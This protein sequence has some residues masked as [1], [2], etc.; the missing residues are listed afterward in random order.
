MIN[1]PF[2]AELESANS[3]D[4]YDNENKL[5]FS[6]INDNEDT[7]PEDLELANFIVCACNKEI[8]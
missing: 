4:I 7:T 8:A 3:V 1:L 5:I 6:I 2:R